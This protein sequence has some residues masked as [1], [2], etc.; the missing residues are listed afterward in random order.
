MFV[1]ERRIPGNLRWPWQTAIPEGSV[2]EPGGF[3]E[4]LAAHGPLGDRLEQ[5]Q[6]IADMGHQQH[7]PAFQ[8]AESVVDESLMFLLV[9][10]DLQWY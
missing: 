2:L 3:G 1:L 9:H 8:V 5:A 6:S 7:H 10:V 4:F